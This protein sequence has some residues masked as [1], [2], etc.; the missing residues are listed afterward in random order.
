MVE[1]ILLAGVGTW[2]FIE[3]LVLAMCGAAK[4]DDEA[5]DRA[6]R[7]PQFGDLGQLADSPRADPAG[8]PPQHG[9]DGSPAARSPA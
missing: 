8:L 7:E 4:A 9:L 5:M 6:L 1:M 2:I 3:V